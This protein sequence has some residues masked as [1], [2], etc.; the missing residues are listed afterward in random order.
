M[1]DPRLVIIRQ[2]VLVLQLP[3]VKTKL[4]TDDYELKEVI[5]KLSSI[6]YNQ[7]STGHIVRCTN[8][9]CRDLIDYSLFFMCSCFF[10][11]SSENLD[12][13]LDN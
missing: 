10:K 3:G 8:A 7:L 6:L 13:K 5:I 4:F 1:Y 2:L 11:C 12:D 9:K